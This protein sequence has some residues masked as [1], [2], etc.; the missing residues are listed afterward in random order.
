MVRCCSALR[1]RTRSLL[2]HSREKSSMALVNGC[3]LFMVLRQPFNSSSISRGAF[4]PFRVSL[5]YSIA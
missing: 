1:T 4:L 2:A 5:T 3:H